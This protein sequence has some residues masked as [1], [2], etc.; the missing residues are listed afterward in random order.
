VIAIVDYGRG[1][2]FG[3]GRA[4]TSLGLAHTISAD[5]QVIRD[6]ER[7]LLPGVG[8]FGAARA[9]LA[10]SG[11]DEVIVAAAGKGTPVLGICLGMQLLVDESDEFGQH[12]GLGLIRGRVERLPLGETRIPNVGWRELS[13]TGIDP[14]LAVAEG[15][16]VYFNHS[17]GVT[18]QNPQTVTLTIT[19]NGRT[20]AAG[21]RRGR[22]AGFQFHPEKSGPAGL[23][24]LNLFS[25][26]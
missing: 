10:R 21:I 5:A 6:A 4:L 23:Q 20:I 9:D 12:A 7:I 19:V 11:L 17:F 1:N 26:Q 15:Q 16:M 8:A 25:R 3:L 14:A 18:V 2:L 22:V 13:A 24:L